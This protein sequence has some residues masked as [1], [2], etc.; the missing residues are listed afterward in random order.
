MLPELFQMLQK[1]MFAT[2]I[3]DELNESLAKLEQEGEPHAT[4]VVRTQR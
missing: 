4:K 1:S 2:D 3:I